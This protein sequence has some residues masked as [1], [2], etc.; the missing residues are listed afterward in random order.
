MMSLKLMQYLLLMMMWKCGMMKSFWPSGAAHFASYYF[1]H[2]ITACYWHK[3]DAG[4]TDASVIFIIKL[5][6]SK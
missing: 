5:V 6:F 4:T 2:F 1:F 3:K